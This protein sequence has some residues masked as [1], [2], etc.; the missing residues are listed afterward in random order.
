M[1]ALLP[2]YDLA[3]AAAAAGLWYIAPELGATVLPLALAPWLLRLALT[4][5][6]SLLTPFAPPLALFGLTAVASVWAAY[7]LPAAWA[8]FWVIVAGFFLFYAFANGYSSRDPATI[9]ARR[10][11]WLLACLGAAV[12]LYFV[13]THDWDLSPAKVVALERL[14]R[15]IQAALPALPGHRLHPNVAGGILAALAPFA[16]AS[17][18]QG[19]RVVRAPWVFSATLTGIILLG[20]ALS[21]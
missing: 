1:R 13:A 8:K 10:Q 15:A 7:D 17:F 11:G 6:L 3:C 19:G 5:R 12:S 18:G 21:T 20:L 9:V 14:G 16:V 2:Y 4:R